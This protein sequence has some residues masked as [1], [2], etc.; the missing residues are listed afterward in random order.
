M[1]SASCPS[2]N[3]LGTSDMGRRI[4][5]FDWSDHPLGPIEIWPKSLKTTIQIMLNS[6]YAMW[7]G[8]GSE[9]YFFCNNAYLPTLGIK[10]NWLGIPAREV[11][12]E[13]WDDIGPARNPSSR[14]ARRLGTNPCCSS[15]NEAVIPKK[16]TT[17]F[18]T[19]PFLTIP[20]IPEACSRRYRRYG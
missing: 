15:S 14:P 11:W 19:V 12:R 9:F 16:L 7:M 1:S 8:W 3:W 10:K 20:A 13:I 17:R 6:R 4:S 2:V 18:L 5:A